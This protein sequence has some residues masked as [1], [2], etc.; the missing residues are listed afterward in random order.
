MQK[1]QEFKLKKQKLHDIVTELLEF[2]LNKMHH[3][4]LKYIQR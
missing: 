3:H 4:K 1:V 2:T